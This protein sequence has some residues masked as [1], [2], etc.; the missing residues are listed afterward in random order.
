L[1]LFETVEIWQAA[2]RGHF[3]SVADSELLSSVAVS[4]DF[5][6]N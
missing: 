6:Y 2:M 3:H 5:L 4:D 1:G